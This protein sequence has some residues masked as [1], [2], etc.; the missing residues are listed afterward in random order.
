MAL[1]LQILEFWQGNRERNPIYMSW[2]SSFYSIKAERVKN[3]HVGILRE[4][5]LKGV[6]F[7]LPIEG[8]KELNSWLS[9]EGRGK[10]RVAKRLIS[11]KGGNLSPG[12]V[13]CCLTLK[14][15]CINSSEYIQCF[16]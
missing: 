4:H 11:I 15:H 3:L 8:V 1:L 7:W 16:L 9:E 14:F 5:Y 2:S 12:A 6:Q 13:N 10:D